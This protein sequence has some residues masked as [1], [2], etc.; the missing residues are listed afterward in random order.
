MQARKLEAAMRTIEETRKQLAQSEQ[1]QNEQTRKLEAARR[2][3]RKTRRQLAQKERQ[4]HQRGVRTPGSDDLTSTRKA[5][6]R[7]EFGALPDFLIIG[8]ER[9]GRPS[10]TGR[11]ASI[12]TSSPPLRRSCTSSTPA[13][14]SRGASDGIGLSF[15]HRRGERVRRLSPERQAL[16]ISSI[17]LHLAGRRT[18]CPMQS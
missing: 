8:T 10:C 9:V 7:I 11:C 13:S 16:T 5:E 17:P 14:G 4:L 1:Q 15:P 12:L 3:V 18:S 6:S 2:K